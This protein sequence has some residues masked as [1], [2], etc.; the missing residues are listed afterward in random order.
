ME[1]RLPEVARALGLTVESD[2]RV[3]GWS[4]DSRTIAPGDLFFALRGPNHDGNAYVDEVLRKGAIAAVA[5]A[6]I[7]SRD[8]EGAVVLP[9]S[10]TLE[11]L[12]NTAVWALGQWGGEVIGV[13]GS[14]GKTST[15]DVI[16]SMLA[17]G[18]P[19]G[20]TIGNLNNHVG[21][22]LSILRLPGEARVAVLEM[23]M[24]HAG[25]IRALC[26]IAKPRIGVVTNVGHAHMEAFDSIE[27]VAAAKREL[28][29]SLPPD[30][31][32]VLNA[33]DPLVS[34]FRAAHAGY[35]LT[36]GIDSPADLRA[37]DVEITARGVS[38]KVDGV[39]FES[40]LV[41]RHSVS[42]IL[43]G[44]AV[45]SLY[46][47]R[48]KQ[49]VDVV[50]DLAASSMRGQRLEHEGVV[51]LNDCY[52]SNPDA[53][54][55]MIDVLR[56]TPAKRRIA[57]LGEMLEL[58]RWSESLHRDVGSYAAKSGIDVLVGIRGE[59]CHLVDAAR[60][61][62]LAVD[63]AFFFPDAEAAGERLRRIAHPGDVILFKGSRGTHVEHALERFLARPN[64]P[65]KGAEAPTIH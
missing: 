9:V 51:I 2:A 65:A 7:P 59:A 3:T 21:V 8:R 46:G 48:P 13:T 27:G 40:A 32:A 44:L 14:A 64:E 61:A 47:I 57:V 23:G 39:R 33:D 18:M 58:G 28:I 25:E 24:N 11:A 54:R 45:A 41:G 38:F 56:E 26:A 22:P 53:A 55:V 4:I 43:A 6:P 34:K 52:N 30:G 16:A 60:Q 17:A 19:V 37:D 20:K 15:K 12:Q 36:F 49:L 50:K 35:T 42:N 5:N 1:F 31:V 63:A 29:E 10:D 62:G